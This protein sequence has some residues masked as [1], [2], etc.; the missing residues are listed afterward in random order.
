VAAVAAAADELRR[1]RNGED[2]TYVVNRNIQFTNVCVKRCGFCAFSR[3]V[4]PREGSDGTAKDEGY[5]LP[6]E[7]IVRRAKEAADL[8]ATEICVQAGLP[9]AM[10]PNLYEEIAGAIKSAV[11]DLHLH[12]FSPEE[13]LYGARTSKR[14]V[15]EMLRA[16]RAAGVDSLPG[17][18]AEILDDD[19]RRRLAAGRL[20][21]EEWLEVIETAH[22]E[23]IP[24]TS[25]M[26]Y[27][28]VE[29]PE[30]IAAHLDL[31]RGVQARALARGGPGR[32]TEFVPLSF[33]AAE[34]P[35]Y[36]LGLLPGCRSGPGGVEVILAHAVARIV[37]DGAVDNIQA[38]W[39]KEGPRMAQ[40][41]LHAGVNDLGGTLVNE[42]ISTSAGS[43]HG[44]RLRPE[45]LRE[46]ARG[47]GRVPVERSTT[48][49]VLRRFPAELLG[50]G[51]CEGVGAEEGDEVWGG[52]DERF[53]SYQRLASAD[54]WRFRSEVAARRQRPARLGLAGP[55]VD[56]APTGGASSSTASASAA[57]ASRSFASFAAAPVAS[58]R[59]ARLAPAAGMEKGGGQGPLVTYSPSFTVVPTFECF[60]SCAYCNFRASKGQPRAEWSRLEDVRST[61]EALRR[62]DADV[63]EIL[64][65]SGEVHPGSKRRA[66][67]LE[68]S[69]EIC[70]LAQSMGFLP[71]TNVG[72]LT[73][74][75]MGRLSAANASM[76]LMLEQ[77]SQRLYKS[78]EGP[79]A[80][81]APSKDPALRRAQL[82]LAGE[83][84]IPFTTGVLLGVGETEGDLEETLDCIAES[85]RRYGHVQECIV[86]PYRPGSRDTW[87]PDAPYDLERL[88]AAVAQAR[89]RLPDEV[90][91]QVPPNLVA[92]R[93]E[94]LRAC[95][96]AGA[97]DLGGIS[98]RD[99]AE[100]YI[101]DQ[102]KHISG[103]LTAQLAQ[104]GYRLAP[105]SAVHDRLAPWAFAGR[106]LS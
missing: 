39:V 16:L 14:T 82:D 65:L 88:P 25:T 8:G 85:Q 94:V 52:G 9:P 38:S 40:L 54:K 90:V 79:Y 97:R 12:A 36:R 5:F 98:P 35:M 103:E 77:M 64:V 11:P 95:L 3:T 41:L 7:E 53:G 73:R 18:S 101:P 37:L 56:A 70:S 19:V 13:V 21:T 28:H 26:M 66:A 32:L 43:K 68:L 49:G 1:R 91:V 44:Q 93:P 51:E 23:G 86:Q 76:G 92:E 17:T 105:R 47:A 75:E 50:A 6:T 102:H 59:G 80:R 20:S 45:E 63:S 106:G 99:E 29:T 78:K 57:A 60:N 33:V 62:R 22:A 83:L 104:W 74:G 34:A 4:A 48:Y 27:G 30:D 67:W 55:S 2:V 61:L 96:E 71:H 42:S 89:S 15:S 69:L 24:T 10:H 31:L 84:K 87:A 72:P 58:E 81:G 100:A 46:I